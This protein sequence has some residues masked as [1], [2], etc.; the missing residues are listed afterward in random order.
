MPMASIVRIFQI[1]SYE[2]KTFEHHARYIYQK[3]PVE[4]GLPAATRFECMSESS[5]DSRTGSILKYCD[6]ILRVATNENKHVTSPR[7]VRVE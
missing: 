5:I 4:T 2:I 3:H 1:V 7:C 6:I